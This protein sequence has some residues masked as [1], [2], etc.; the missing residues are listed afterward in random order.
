MADGN[1]VRDFVE[2]PGWAG[3]GW[4]IV[5]VLI[6]SALLAWNL[7]VRY[8]T[9]LNFAKDTLE[10]P[11]APPIWAQQALT[12]EGCV[13]AALDWARE[14][15]GIKSLCDVYVSHVTELC[16][17]S[18]DRSAYCRGLAG[19][20]GL[21]EF[22]YEECQQRGVQRHID[23]EA[24]ANAFRQIDTHCNRILDAGGEEVP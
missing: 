5:P 14:C 9:F 15:H 17:A 21:T 23:N 16:L 7:G 6:L 24:C 10:N 2:R 12:P 13:D 1:A 22:G 20:S 18:Q 8:T 4:V 3:A 11:D 19:R